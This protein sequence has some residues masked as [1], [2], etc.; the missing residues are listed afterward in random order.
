LSDEVRGNYVSC[1]QGFFVAQHNDGISIC[2]IS[3]FPI[4]K[5]CAVTTG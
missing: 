5:K 3:S 1:R 4:T 2:N